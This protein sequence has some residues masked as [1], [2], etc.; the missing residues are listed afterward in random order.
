MRVSQKSRKGKFKKN[1][2]EVDV[3]HINKCTKKIQKDRN[4][5]QDL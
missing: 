4:N 2:L 1:Y 5:R 3:N